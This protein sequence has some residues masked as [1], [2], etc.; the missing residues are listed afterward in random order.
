MSPASITPH[1]PQAS[2]IIVYFPPQLILDRHA[3]ELGGEGSDGF[4]GQGTDFCAG[5]DGEFGE[6]AGGVLM[7]DS[8]KRFERFLGEEESAELE[9]REVEREVWSWC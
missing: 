5:E 6:D 2:N 7:S 3:G 4:V 8:V 1:I 9:N